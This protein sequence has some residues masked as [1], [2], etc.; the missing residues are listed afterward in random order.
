[1]LGGICWL[2]EVG[3]YIDEFSR[4]LL[5]F[6]EEGQQNEILTNIQFNTNQV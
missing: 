5:D 3:R 1:M 6:M 4:I 2:L